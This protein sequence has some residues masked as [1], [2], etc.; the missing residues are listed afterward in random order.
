MPSLRCTAARANNAARSA[1]IAA[2]WTIQRAPRARCIVHFAAI[3]A[4]RAALFALAAVH[5]KLGIAEQLVAFRRI[6]GKQRKAD[7]GGEV[8]RL[9]LNRKR[10]RERLR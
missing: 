5:R 6:G 1:C 8:D 10:S 9:I 7:R 2:K 4:D 3:H